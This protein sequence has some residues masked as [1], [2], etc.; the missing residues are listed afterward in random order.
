MSKAFANGIWFTAQPAQQLID[1]YGDEEVEETEEC[2]GCVFQR[3]PSSACKAA[4]AAAV[5]AGLPNCESRPDKSDPGYVYQKLKS[6]QPKE[7]EDAR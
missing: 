5:Q 1:F 2:K 7:N 3:K 4:G 6:H